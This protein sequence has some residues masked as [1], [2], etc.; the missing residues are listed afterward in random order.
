MSLED[1]KV[2]RQ[3]ERELNRFQSL[4]VTDTRVQ[5]IHGTAYVGGI[6]RPATGQYSL[7]IKEEMRIFTEITLKV[8]GIRGLTI[9]ARLETSPR[10]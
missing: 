4:D 10:R 7:N 1:K 6:I 3:L 8:P 5:V 2:T 9:D